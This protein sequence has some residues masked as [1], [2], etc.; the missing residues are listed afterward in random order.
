MLELLNLTQ[1]PRIIAAIASPGRR[2]PPDVFRSLRP[3]L[4]AEPIRCENSNSSAGPR[5]VLARCLWVVWDVFHPSL[6]GIHI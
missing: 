1:A 5:S 6:V 2:G 3:R 4:P